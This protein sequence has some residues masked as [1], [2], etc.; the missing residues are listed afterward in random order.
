[1]NRTFRLALVLAACVTATAASARDLPGTLRT[2]PIHP[3][4]EKAVRAAVKD[5][6]EPVLIRFLL[7]EQGVRLYRLEGLDSGRQDFVLVDAERPVTPLQNVTGRSAYNVI[8]G[9][10]RCVVQ[11]FGS[12]NYGN[13]I[14][15]SD[16][17]W[18][19]LG[20]LTGVND[21]ASSVQTSCNGVW[22][23]EHKNYDAFGLVL[24][25]PANTNLASLHATIDN[26][27][28]AVQHDL[29]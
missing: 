27:I 2:A 4:L 9:A 20:Y 19:N 11:L 6:P 21:L 7:A 26:R 13:L 16:I 28:S 10:T 25:V 18:N 12:A 3:S 17:D 23:Y 22:L 29:P 24:Y 14:L 5:A 8:G 1:M 15:T